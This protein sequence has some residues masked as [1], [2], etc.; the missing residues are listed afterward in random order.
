MTT[1]ELLSP[2]KNLSCGISAIDHGADA[3][4]IGADRF[5]A[6]AAAGNSLDDIKALC[7]YAHQY[8]AR[9]YVT[10]NTI[11]YDN[12][13]EQTIEL[14]KQLQAIGVDAL[15]LQDMGI[16]SLL[17][18]EKSLQDL[19]LHASTQTDNRTIEKVRWLASK[20]FKRVVLARELS[21]KE[22]EEIHTNVPDVELE[23]FVH[24]AL[25]VSYSG[26]CYASQYCFG[27]SA[28][29][30]ECAQ[31]CR[32]PFTLQDANGDVI[33]QNSHI[34][35]LKDMAQINNLE[36]LALAG[37]TSFKIEGR[38]KD[39]DYVKNV[40]AAYSERL[41]EICRKYPDRFTRMSMGKCSYTF[42]A[43]IQKSFNRGF[44]TYFFNGRQRGLVSP[45]TPKA[46]GE[47][48][49]KTKDIRGNFIIVSSTKSFNNGDGLCFFNNKK[50][51]IGFRVNKAVGNK[52]FPLQMPRD[53]RTGME[54]YRNHDQ[55]FDTLLNK[56]S[57]QRKIEVN[58][59]LHISDDTL[60]LRIID[61]HNN[62]Y[63]STEPYVYSIAEK[64][65][66]E[67]IC[68]QL[69]KLGGTPYICKDIEIIAEKD[70]PF[71][72]NSILSQL[73]RACL[74]QITSETNKNSQSIRNKTS[75]S[76]LSPESLPAY[77][78]PYLYNATNEAA[79]SFYKNLGVAVSGF[80]KEMPS[81]SLLMQ[82]RY[83]IRYELGYCTK[84]GRKAPWKEPLI[85]SLNDG[86]TFRVKF[87]CKNCQMEI[88]T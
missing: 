79:K 1:L 42:K 81:E 69:T 83:C 64:P 86:K 61:E 21:L 82:C 9:V 27:R 43:D 74:S 20:G 62:E 88:W 38:L 26:Q 54:L 63:V 40:T 15:L 8:D 25:C 17:S 73:K 58:M 39:A 60:T 28:N 13:I 71:I 34:L 33:E 56:T 85:L 24:G 14:C 3:V 18:K 84:T 10:V 31:F 75:E 51:L 29:R 52:L 46:I 32:L 67:N 55:E 23:V 19:H 30:G 87:N 65:Q 44:T 47:Y 4:Y 59:S 12:E 7:D 66:K 5:G 2:A 77:P 11:I 36:K 80:E 70:I 6:R 35:S 48:V 57:A 45:N 37:A 16:L 76:L 50:E 72:Q 68:R 78:I 53:L 41:N 49:G 22:I